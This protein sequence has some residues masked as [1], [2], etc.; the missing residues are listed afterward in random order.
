M[1]NEERMLNRR[2]FLRSSSGL[3]VYLPLLPSLFSAKDALAA[4]AALKRLVVIHCGHAQVAGQWF[5]KPAGFQWTE[6]SVTGGARQADLSAING[7]IS[8]IL[9][10]GFSTLKQKLLLLGRLSYT[11]NTPN[12]NAEAL[13]SGGIRG[14]PGC[15]NSLDV[16]I[17][18]QVYNSVP[19]NMIVNSPHSDRPDKYQLSMQ[20][21]NFLAGGSNPAVVFMRLFGNTNPGT[22]G[23]G[24][25]MPAEPV[26]AKLERKK[27]VDHVLEQYKALL[28]NPKISSDDKKNLLDPH[29][30]YLSELQGKLMPSTG[31]GGGTSTPVQCNNP[32]GPSSS[33]VN[34]RNDKDYEVVVEQSFQVLGMALKCGIES[35]ATLMLHPYDY[36]E[37]QV[38]GLQGT[39][40]ESVGHANDDFNKAQKLKLQ[41][42]YAGHVSKFIADLNSVQEGSSGGSVLDSTCVIW[43]NDMGAAHNPNNHARKNL[44]I[45][46]AGAQKTFKTGLLVDF[47]ASA[48]KDKIPTDNDELGRPI[49]QLHISILKGFGVDPGASGFGNYGSWEKDFKTAGVT[50][51]RTAGLPLVTK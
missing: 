14:D 27:A 2:L 20:N 44:P 11:S 48:P 24:G 7:P 37:G 21:G 10:E 1:S 34:T 49:N 41:R 43:G 26:K 47:G 35:V 6:S 42:F 28:K 39:F 13:L 3:L 45:L 25:D 8:D 22:P 4:D 23:N 40:H 18:R 30:S 46:I 33:P 29:M 51:I 50:D 32:M 17:A 15:E 38:M 5:P 19:L 9:D 31:G 36:F 16:V 12:H